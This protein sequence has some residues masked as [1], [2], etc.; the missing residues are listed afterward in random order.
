MVV[1]KID[2]LQI[3]QRHVEKSE[4]VVMGQLEN[5]S[6]F[7]TRDVIHFVFF[8]KNHIFLLKINDL[9]IGKKEVNGFFLAVE[10]ANLYVHM[11]KHTVVLIR[12]ANGT[13]AP[14]RMVDHA[15]LAAQIGMK[16]DFNSL[17]QSVVKEDFCRRTLAS[18]RE[19]SLSLE[20]RKHL[21]MK[22]HLLHHFSTQFFG[23]E[24]WKKALEATTDIVYNRKGKNRKDFLK[25]K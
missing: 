3:L 11:G 2:E 15:Q 24:S 20:A 25:K 14:K 21:V 23:T 4:I 16:S 18:P 19:S 22:Y 10:K 13:F 7:E 12:K 1:T 9:Q 6:A 5:N 8:V 17:A